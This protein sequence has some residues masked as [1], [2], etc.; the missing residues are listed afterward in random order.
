MWI[1]TVEQSSL[2]TPIRGEGKRCIVRADDKLTAFVELESAIR[3]QSKE[4]LIDRFAG[5]DET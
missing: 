4:H 2:L 1:P 5:I 3:K